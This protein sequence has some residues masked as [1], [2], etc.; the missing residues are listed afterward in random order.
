MDIRTYLDKKRGIQ[1]GADQIRLALLRL[2]R[3]KTLERDEGADGQYE[4]HQ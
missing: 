1:L 4:Y 2:V 3:D